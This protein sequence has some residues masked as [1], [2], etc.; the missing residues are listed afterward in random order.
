ML[1]LML[2]FASRGSCPQCGYC[3]YDKSRN[4]QRKALA[5][6]AAAFGNTAKHCHD[7]LR[8]VCS[9][10]TSCTFSML[11]FSTGCQ[12]LQQLNSTLDDT[13]FESNV[14]GTTAMRSGCWIDV[15]V[16]PF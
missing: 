4:V 8:C 11:A 2:F 3:R 6:S 10:G 13:Q 15:S 12:D 14:A 1:T 7:W 5:C 9:L 16:N